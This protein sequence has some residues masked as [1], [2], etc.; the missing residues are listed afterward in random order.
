MVS[1]VIPALNEERTIGV[2]LESL[3]AMK[4]STEVIVSDGQSE[5]R[6]GEIAA[7]AGAVV[8]RCGRGRGLQQRAGAAAAAGDVLWFL[9]A[10]SVV[11]PDSLKAIY[12]ALADPRVIA[13]NFRLVFDG[14]GLTSRQM[15]WIYPKLQ[16]LG[17]SYGDAGIFVR[18]TSYEKIGGF[19]AHPLFEDLDLIRRLKPLGR[20]AHLDCPIRTSSRRFEGRNYTRAWMTWIA[21]QLLYWAGVSPS[22]LSRWY[23]PAQ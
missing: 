4:G 22:R 18:R 5:D 23:R 10:D 19:K 15:T 16:L 13:G 8:V 20:F 7:S 11:S 17:L 3:R 12:D 1:I 14:D 6:T 2:L 9:H 21:L